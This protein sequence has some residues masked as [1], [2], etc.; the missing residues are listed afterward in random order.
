MKERLSSCIVYNHTMKGHRMTDKQAA[1]LEKQISEKPDDVIS[2][3]ILLGYY[4][5]RHDR[6]AKEKHILWLI[7]NAPESDVLA[8][9]EGILNPIRNPE[10][11]TQGKLAWTR[12]IEKNPTS[13]KVL[14]NAANFFL[15]HDRNMAEELLKKGRL[16]DLD[17][18]M[19][20]TALGQLYMLN[21]SL[22]AQKDAAQKAIEQ[23]ETAYALSS[24][25]DRDPLLQ[26]LAKA[27][28]AADNLEKAGQYAN[29]MLSQN[30]Q[31][32][33]QGNNVH[34][35]NI[36]LGEIELRSNNI[37]GAKDY[38]IKAGKTSGSPQLD[39][40]G[41]DLALAEELFE[42]GE[43]KTVLEY[44]DLCSKFWETGKQHLYQ[45]TVDIQE[46]KVPHFGHRP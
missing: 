23:F 43:R 14:E 33:N 21:V 27:A 28:L 18:P 37:E 8:L 22:K 35:G 34:Y 46:G 1:L 45:W 7:S 6:K 17:E 26:Y 13:L 25:T 39:S 2:R 44:L 24:E 9:S 12:H 4:F 40:F 36:I 15:L 29:Q 30:M 10:A 16:L 19:W 5:S 32:W 3:T 20:P 38:L 31:D 11:Y 42:Q 41:P